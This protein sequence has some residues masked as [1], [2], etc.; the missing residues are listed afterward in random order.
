MRAARVNAMRQTRTNAN[1]QGRTHTHTSR[2]HHHTSIIARTLLLPRLRR[3]LVDRVVGAAVHVLLNALTQAVRIA[4]WV[5]AARPVCGSVQWCVSYTGMVCVE[6][7]LRWGRA[8]LYARRVWVKGERALTSTT[9]LP[10]PSPQCSGHHH[11][12]IK[13]TDDA[14]S[15]L[16]IYP[17]C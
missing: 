13:C 9:Q 14:E 7:C 15:A 3:V 2:P 6:G 1:T 17:R 4:P 12:A 10:S 8:R 16:G 11:Q 5:D